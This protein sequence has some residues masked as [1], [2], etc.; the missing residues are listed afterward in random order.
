[1]RR[2][3][4]ARVDTLCIDMQVARGNGDTVERVWRV[5]ASIET[6]VKSGQNFQEAI[7]LAAEEGWTLVSMTGVNE[8]LSTTHTRTLCYSRLVTKE[9]T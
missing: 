2:K 7:D 9:V 6:P 4:M 3:I 8:R 1:M 5:F